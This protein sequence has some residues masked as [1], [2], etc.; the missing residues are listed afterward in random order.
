[1]DKIIKIIKVEV[2]RKS[3]NK[4]IYGNEGGEECRAIFEKNVLKYQTNDY[5]ITWYDLTSHYADLY[6]RETHFLKI[7]KRL[8]ELKNTDIDSL[9]IVEIR[10]LLKAILDLLVEREEI[11]DEE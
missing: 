7:K 9:A 5:K 3:D 10:K 11:S 4:L 2:F 6:R 8:K 1:M